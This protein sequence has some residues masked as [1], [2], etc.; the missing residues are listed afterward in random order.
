MS[1]DCSPWR[2]DG[3]EEVDAT[4][5]G[6]RLRVVFP[7]R[8]L[9]PSSACFVSFL[10]A[11]FSFEACDFIELW[12]LDWLLSRPPEKRLREFLSYE[13]LKLII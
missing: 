12:L 1:E 9:N 8:A 6:S 4:A 5:E 10:C 11:A 3:F 13:F 7:L 2:N